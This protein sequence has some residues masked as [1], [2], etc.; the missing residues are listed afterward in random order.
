MRRPRPAVALLASLALLTS[1][2]GCSTPSRQFT[3]LHFND[4]HGQ[5][6][7][8]APKDGPEAGGLARLAGLS[9]AIRAQEKG[10]GVPTLLLNAGDN[11][12]GTAF[13]TLFQGEPEYH[14]FSM[15]GMDALVTGNHEWDFGA[16]VLEA[17]ARAATFPVLAANVSARDPARAFLEPCATLLAGSLRIGVIGVTTA[18]TPV[19][20]APGNTAGFDFGDPVEAVRRVL[21]GPPATGWDF[22]VVLSHCGFEVDKAI[23]RANPRVGL[24][25]GGHDHK[26]LHTPFVENGVPI[27]QAGDRGRF[28][29]RVSVTLS[30][31]KRA[32]VEGTLIPVSPGT[33]EDPAARSY[34]QTYLDRERQTLGA[35]VGHL[36]EA[37]PGERE[38]LR[39]RESALGDLLTDAMR[40]ASGADAAFINAGAIRTGLP[41]GPV[42]GLDLYACL[43]FFDS[44][45]TVRMTGAQV[46]ALLD[47]CAAMPTTDA[48]GG[49][50]AFSGIQATYREGRAVGVRVG[51]E[52][53]DQA[54]S[55]LVACSHFLLGGG[56]GH[57]EFGEGKESRDWGVGLQELMRR[58]LLK[59]GLKIARP[60]G[61]LVRDD[62][63]GSGRDPAPSP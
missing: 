52:P 3:I 32:R 33:P 25:V 62:S 38:I 12:T 9:E 20:T 53:L 39:T 21:A 51:G 16:G 10:L 55:Y 54:K 15:M 2:F 11:F 34:L 23:A 7:P 59:P 19:T 47:R 6:E 14:V 29:G 18:D 4:F 61:R 28:L 56:D 37:L 49:F 17:R 63:A 13:S 40:A 22:V 41:A 45:A 43:P 60:G 44:L 8:V 57:R 50:L 35:V 58:Q 5:V 46:Q 48:P 42:T 27:V 24:V 36:P 26:E 31:G 1:L 30:R